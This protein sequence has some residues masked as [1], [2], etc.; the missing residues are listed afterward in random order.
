MLPAIRQKET[1]LPC[2]FGRAAEMGRLQLGRT[3]LECKDYECSEDDVY[4]PKEKLRLWLYINLTDACPAGCPFCVYSAPEG[5]TGGR[6]NP[7]KLRHMLS[8]VSPFVSGVTLTGGEPMTDIPLLEETVS[9]V[10][11]TVPPEIELDMAT[12]GLHIGKLPL[13]KGLERF[14]TMHISRHAAGDEQNRRLMNWE[15]APPAEA[16]KETFSALPDRGLTVLNCVLQK[17]GVHDADTVREY[18]EKAAWM[19]AA[20]VSLI[21]M[22]LANDYCREN[23]ISPAVLDFSGDSRFTVW[24]HFHDHE[25]CQCSSGDYKAEAGYIRYYYRCPGNV[26]GPEYCRQLVYGTD[27]HLRAGFDNAEVIEL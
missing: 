17:S 19:G 5:K 7:E 26:K 12:N 27:N 18:L 23:Y 15:D 8:C 24:N 9:V 20:N 25:Y 14:A 22:F 13:L 6:V 10:R 16:L 11:E 4:L 1:D 21:G 2:S 3:L